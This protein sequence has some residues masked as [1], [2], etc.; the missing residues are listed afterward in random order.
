MARS[1]GTKKSV[2]PAL[3]TIP[4]DATFDFVSSST[5]YKITS[6]DF[7]TALGVSGVIVSEGGSGSA[8][9]L[10]DQGSTKAIR[11]LNAGAGITIAVDAD[12]GLEL[13]SDFSFNAVGSGLVDDSAASPLVFRSIVGG[14]GLTVSDTDGEILIN[15]DAPFFT[16]SVVVTSL[17]DLPTPVLTVI[18]LAANTLYL[19]DGAIN[20]GANTIVLSANSSIAGQGAGVSSLTTSSSGTLF[21]ATSSFSLRDFGITATSATLFGCTGSG[22]EVATIRNMNIINVSSLGTFTTWHSMVLDFVDIATFTTKL[23]FV[24][25]CDVAIFNM[26]RL[27]AGYT[28]GI[29]FGTAT[30]DSIQ[31]RNCFFENASATNH[32][33]LAA[34]S[35]NINAGCVGRII[36]TCFN[37]GATNVVNG[38]DV[39]DTLWIYMSNGNLADTTRNGQMYMH[40]QSTTTISTGVGDSGNPIIVDAGASWVDAH[41][42]QFTISTAGRLT[43]NGLT[44][45]EFNVSAN[46]AG[47]VAAGTSTFNFYLAKNGTIITASKT[48]K[49]FVST[50]VGSPAQACAIITLSTDDYIELFVENTTDLDNW[51]SEILNVVVGEA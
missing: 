34:N 20:I 44:N 47:T 19:I 14:D 51:V 41:S 26:V 3:T 48:E 4:A 33:I 21:T 43:Y 39:G 28:T 37:A 7:V 25:A 40:T 50:A 13:S 24:G 15:N 10:D 16:N 46:I 6:A 1:D 42:D 23:S 12:N 8:D 32:I 49:E 30:F 18:T 27:T 17:A 5:N 22:S 35:A 38:F 9:V 36:N 29:D 45:K 31:V 2:F 11:K